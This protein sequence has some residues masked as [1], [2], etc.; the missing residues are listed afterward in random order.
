[1]NENLIHRKPTEVQYMKFE[2]ISAKTEDE[3]DSDCRYYNDCSI[4]P[5]AIHQ[6]LYSTIKHTCVQDMT[7]RQFEIAMDNADCYF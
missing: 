1:M 4:C 3:K 2:H 7:R 5:Y 6:E